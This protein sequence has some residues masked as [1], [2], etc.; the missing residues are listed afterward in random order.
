M[1]RKKITRIGLAVAF[2]GVSLM[3]FAADA[4]AQG[5][6][7]ENKGN[8]GEARQEKPQKQEKPQ[9]VTR[10]ENRP[11]R[12]DRQAPP[13]QPTQQRAERPTRPAPIPAQPQQRERQPQQP[14][15]DRGDWGRQ[16]A[17]QAQERN[18]AWQR[19]QRE[20]RN[21]NR[22]R[23]PVGSRSSEIRTR[24]DAVRNKTIK[25]TRD[26]A[27]AKTVRLFPGPT[28]VAGP[29]A[30]TTTIGETIANAGPMNCGA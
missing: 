2:G 3:G 17:A 26:G 16:R 15:Q 23:T 1:E 14:A 4:S 22:L 30:L 9:Q 8:R 7:R 13:Q 20:A 25:M 10:R 19:A 29:V 11:E 24:L 6:G 18:E 5:R 27:N 21:A 12:P 28:A